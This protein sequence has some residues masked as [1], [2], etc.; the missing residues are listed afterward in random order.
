[1]RVEAATGKPKAGVAAAAFD[2]AFGAVRADLALGV[3]GRLGIFLLLACGGRFID[4][5]VTMSNVGSKFKTL[6][7]T[8]PKPSVSPS[9]STTQ[10]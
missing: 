10:R 4:Q 6:A 5:G 1:L 9:I 7:N 2:V 8:A 3:T